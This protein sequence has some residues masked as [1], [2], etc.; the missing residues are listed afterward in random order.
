MWEKVYDGGDYLKNIYEHSPSH[1]FLQ[2]FLRLRVSAVMVR[3]IWIWS[4]FC[5]PNKYMFVYI[6]KRYKVLT[7]FFIFLLSNLNLAAKICNKHF[8]G[9]TLFHQRMYVMERVSRELM[10]FKTDITTSLQ[11]LYW[12]FAT[13]S[14]V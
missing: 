7:W 4:I 14:V 2:Q 13:K 3:R 10:T 5:L 6:T 12:P 11:L 1:L 8:F 9:E